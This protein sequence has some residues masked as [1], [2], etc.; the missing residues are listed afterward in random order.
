MDNFH[1]IIK[2]LKEI[3]N[4]V[5]N[6]SFLKSLIVK[7]GQNKH[8]SPTWTHCMHYTKI[9][10]VVEKFIFMSTKSR[11]FFEFDD[12]IQGGEELKKNICNKQ[13]ETKNALYI[14]EE[15]LE[16]AQERYSIQI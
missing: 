4:M 12:V 13:Q 6:F 3:Y 2:K 10:V 7:V 16:K 9:G 15:Q 14:E 5:K 8:E 1:H 11:D